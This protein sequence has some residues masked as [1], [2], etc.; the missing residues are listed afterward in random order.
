MPADIDAALNWVKSHTRPVSALAEPAVVRGVLTLL[1]SKLDGTSAAPSVVRRKRAV[2]YNVGEYAKERNLVAVN[3]L[4]LIKWKVPKPVKVVDKRVVVN[5]DQARRLLAAVREQKP[6]GLRL[7]A[8]FAVMYYA[9]LRPGEAVNLRK[10]DLAIPSD[11]WGELL[12]WE[13]APETGASWSDTGTRRDRRQ[14]KHRER[15]DTRPVPCVPPLTRILHEHLEQ[16][17]TDADGYLFRGERET[18]QL[19]ESTSSRAWRLAR[20]TAL[21]AD[22]YASPLARRGYDLRHACLST[23]LNG[24]VPPTQVAEWAGHSVAVLLRVYAQ[25]IAGQE[26]LARR[27]IGEALGLGED[28]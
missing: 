9:G 25:C 15:G 2:L 28:G 5:Q 8:Y 21:S 19:S 12:L 26:D 4:K 27:R 10:Q 17:G 7:V 3:P 20:K 18:G 11:G 22:E 1:S 13:S 24:G 6:S 16:F 23:W 14:L